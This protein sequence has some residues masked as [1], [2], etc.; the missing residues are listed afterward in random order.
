[1][2]DPLGFSKAVL[3][4]KFARLWQS[5]KQK[6]S[7]A[8]RKCCGA[9]CGRGHSTELPPQSSGTIKINAAGTYNLGSLNE[10]LLCK[11]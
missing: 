4:K 6:K 5:A 7:K 9:A 3:V 10:T 8:K 1:M 11:T 2:P